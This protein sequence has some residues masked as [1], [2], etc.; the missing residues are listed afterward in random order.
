MNSR[1]NIVPALTAAFALSLSAVHG[2]SYKEAKFTRLEKDVKV[3]K[4]NAAPRAASVGDIVNA[5]SSVATGPESRAELQFPDKSLTRLGA[6]SRFTIRGEERNLELDKGVMMLQVPK[7]MGGAKVRTAAVTAAITGTTVMYDYQPN[8]YVKLIVIEGVVDIFLNGDPSQV[9]EVHAG[10]MFMMPADLKKGPLPQPVPIDLKRLLET[11]GLL[12]EGENTPNYKEIMG[13]L[14]D[15]QDKI[16]DGSLQE[17]NLVLPGTGQVVSFDNNTRLNLFNGQVAP[18]GGNNGGGGGAPGGGVITT[19]PPFPGFVPLI[20]DTTVLNAGS[21]IKTDPQVRAYNTGTGSVITSEGMVY[22]GSTNGP[23]PYFVFGNVAVRDHLVDLPGFLGTTENPKGDWAVYKFQNLLIN[24]TP[25]IIYN[26]PET[27]AGPNINN[28][29]L[30]A[31]GSI[32]LAEDSSFANGEGHPAA[33][34]GS[35][36]YLSNYGASNEPEILINNLLLYT[37]NGGVELAYGFNV[38]T[39]SQDVGIVGASMISDVSLYGNL[40]VSDGNL[41]VSAGRDVRINNYTSADSV[42]IRAGRDITI[43]GKIAS[44]GD[45]YIYYSY[46]GGI[47]ASNGD[48]LVS[49]KGNL[50][51]TNGAKLK[52]TSSNVLNTLT[53]LSS[54][55]LMRLESLT[56]DVTIDNGEALDS[57]TTLEAPNIEIESKLGNITVANSTINATNALRMS[58]SSPNGRVMS[59]TDSTLKAGNLITLYA[60]GSSRIEF[61]GSVVL[62]SADVQIDAGTVFVKPTGNVTIQQDK[63]TIRA[64]PGGHKYIIGPAGNGTVGAIH[65]ATSNIQIIPA[66]R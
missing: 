33:T 63:A 15:Q 7:Q 53:T 5:V 50:H 31:I 29:A 43:D 14:K 23:F 19:T 37:Q 48:M 18:K 46:D 8:G 39:D 62:D 65:G 57:N 3:L 49:A 28:I 36:L 34:T 11:S 55:A 35:S 41:L 20:K 17:T 27:I 58:V 2:A 6:N 64:T 61:D 59:I 47:T 45:G 30:S 38:I 60:A 4:E 40:S 10:E 22:N 13:A 24:G 56:G 32:K 44:N 25:D 16:K 12:S 66:N 52:V 21:T 54:D 26:W 51:V 1:K 9:V 42:T